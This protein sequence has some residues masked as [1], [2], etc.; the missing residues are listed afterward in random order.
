MYVRG[1]KAGL[2][3]MQ[4]LFADSQLFRHTAK[5]L[6]LSRNW[7]SSYTLFRN[8]WNGEEVENDAH[9]G[10][11][12][13]EKLHSLLQNLVDDHHQITSIPDGPFAM[14]KYTHKIVHV[15]SLLVSPTD[16]DL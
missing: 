14:V 11:V 8:T 7:V 5:Q 12:L 3:R 13:I 16:K 10:T 9:D 6:G 2:N 1:R 4:V 15:L